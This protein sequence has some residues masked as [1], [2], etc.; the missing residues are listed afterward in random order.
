MSDNGVWDVPRVTLGFLMSQEENRL[1]LVK[2]LK[3]PQRNQSSNLWREPGSVMTGR[4]GA[5]RL[6]GLR[7]W[8]Y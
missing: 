5:W 8:G 4:E 1:F 6:D 3:N 2:C 7:H